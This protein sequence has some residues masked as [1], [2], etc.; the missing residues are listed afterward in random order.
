[1]S[2][3][4][5]EH[6]I[7]IE[8][9]M[10]AIGDGQILHKDLNLKVRRDEVMTL[11]GESG[12]GKTQLLRVILGLK[13]PLAGAV[14]VFGVS[15]DDP[16]FKK[17]RRAATNGGAVPEWGALL[18]A[19]GIRQCRVPAARAREASREE[20]PCDRAREA[21]EWSWRRI[22]GHCCRQTYR[23]A[24]LNGSRSRASSSHRTC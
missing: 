21:L 15:W 2:A 4:P 19:D 20:D 10:N 17:V 24:W 14:R 9:L 13:H 18:R 12:S 7:E 1:M 8:G 22:M 5:N 11:V 3:D 23:A 16:S 6:V